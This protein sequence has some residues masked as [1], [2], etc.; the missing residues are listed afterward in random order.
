MAHVGLRIKAE[1]GQ[2]IWDF[3][4]E[5]VQMVMVEKR[6]AVAIHMDKEFVIKRDEILERIYSQHDESYKFD[7]DAAAEMF[8]EKIASCMHD[9][10][11]HWMKYLYSKCHRLGNSD[12][13]AH[14]KDD[15]VIP[16]EYVER[17]Q[18]Q[19]VTPYDIL[20]EKEKDSD[21]EQAD[22]VLAIKVRPNES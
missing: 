14:D 1:A 6:D 15:L 21:R 16:K 2:H 5:A 13:P 9:I 7:E 18:R 17:W 22:K 10:W 20:S 8:R 19:M 3:L 12:G 4:R 11:A